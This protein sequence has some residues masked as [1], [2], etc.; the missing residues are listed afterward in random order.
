MAGGPLRS[1]SLLGAAAQIPARELSLPSPRGHDPEARA[2]IP[3]HR[4]GNC[5]G[6]GSHT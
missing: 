3:G 5:L 1:Y 6:T 4:A 2:G